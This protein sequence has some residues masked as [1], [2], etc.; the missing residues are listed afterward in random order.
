MKVLEGVRVLDLGSY[1]TAPYAAMLLAD[2]GADVVKV[3]KPGTG[4][5]FR[6]F[7]GKL[8]SSQ[9]QA[10]NHN[11]RSLTLDYRKAPGREILDALVSR[12]DVLLTNVRPGVEKQIGIEYARLQALNPR[13]VYCSIT[14]FGASGPYSQ[15]PAYD[16]VGQALSG[17]LSMFHEGSD[18]RVPGPAVADAVTGQFAALG[19]LGALVERFRTGRGRHVEVSMLEAMI[20][21]AAEPLGK[22]FASGQP[23][24]FHARAATS[25]SFIVTCKDG[26]RIGLHLSS[27]EK[28]WTGLVQAINRED[29]L[30]RFPDR[31]SRIQ[32]YAGLAGELEKTFITR[33]RSAWL[34]LLEKHDVPFAAEC[35]LEELEADPQVRHLGVFGQA[36]H[37]QLGPI[38]SINRP[39]RYDDD[40]RSSYRAP[41]SLG[42]HT[43]EVLRE[44]GL[45]GE[46]I[47]GLRTQEVI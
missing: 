20:A 24:G 23:V 2:L 28:F 30:A 16:N 19:I 4:D 35:R 40:N 32:G 11:K 26:R 42:E 34:P 29:L 25:Q 36:M 1:I 31:P 46:A 3:E 8:Y 7:N 27:P 37:A 44:I 17:W 22:L 38:K 18:A 41:P 13:L 21:F 12:A 10:H 47:A 5:P 39:I 33:P 14:G 9:F 6:M 45:S 15:R 43:E